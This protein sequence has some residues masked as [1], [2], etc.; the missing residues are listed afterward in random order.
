LSA[1]SAPPEFTLSAV[2]KYEFPR[3]FGTTKTLR[4][5]F[6]APAA[7]DDEDEDELVA[8]DDADVDGLDDEEHAASRTD[9]MTRDT[10]SHAVC[11]SFMF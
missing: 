4:P 1:A 3:F 7:G 9:T 8:E 2:V 11:L 10:A 6:S 5:F